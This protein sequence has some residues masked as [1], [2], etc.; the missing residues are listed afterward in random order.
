M[1]THTIFSLIRHMT[2]Q[3]NA[4]DLVLAFKELLVAN[5][6]GVMATVYELQSLRSE[7]AKAKQWVCVDCLGEKETQVL[8][9]H[10]VMQR[11]W[12][13]PGDVECGTEDKRQAVAMPVELY[14]KTISH[15]ILLSH[16]FK[17]GNAKEILIGFAHI[18]RDVFRSIHER[19]YDPLTRI[20]NRQA[21]DMVAS[22]L[23][24]GAG[25]SSG[26]TNGNR[27]KVR[28]IAILD[29]DRFKSIND[30]HGHAL[31]D[32][33]LVLFAQTVRSVLRQDDQFFRY[34]GEEF[35]LLIKDVDEQ[36]AHEVLER[37]RTAIERRRF[38]QVGQVTISIGF[39]QLDEQFHPLEN[40]SKADKALYYSKN[41]GRNQVNYYEKL[42]HGGLVE[43]LE[44]SES[45][46]DFWDE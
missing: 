10:S 5:F 26:I 39:A 11:A 45:E 36:Q 19:C 18:F 1:D 41:N 30:T 27:G 20:L 31:G 40:L 35:V 16:P 44:I 32:E 37:C 6:P 25:H 14:D 24:L 29:I 23:A 34:G 12:D 3:T 7:P 4:L 42:V 38:P 9:N 21:F 2:S 17:A 43:A 13:K 33:T 46:V 28:H 22:R 8:A 15:M